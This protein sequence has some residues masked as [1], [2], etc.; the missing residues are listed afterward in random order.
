MTARLCLSSALAFLCLPP[1]KEIIPPDKFVFLQLNLMMVMPL[2]RSG[3][4]W[5][6]VKVFDS[7]FSD[8]HWASGKTSP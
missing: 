3:S 8:T 1:V 4:V 7:I 2:Q 5:V 6:S